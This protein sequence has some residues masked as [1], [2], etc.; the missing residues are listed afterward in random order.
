MEALYWLIAIAVMLLI[1]IM[2]LGLTTIWF[3]GGALIAFFIAL[4]HGSFYLQLFVFVIVSFV[5]LLF[6]RPIALRYFNKSRT[7]TNIDA[8]IGMEARVLEEINNFK[9]TGKVD[10]NGQEWT[11]RQEKQSTEEAGICK[12]KAVIITGVSGVKL[13]VKLKE[14]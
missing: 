11:A 9:G 10:L 13:L 2:T 3:A 5:L 1:E 7:K 12:G 6:T 14:L 4:F 8:L